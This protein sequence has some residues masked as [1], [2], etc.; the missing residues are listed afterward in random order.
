MSSPGQE[1][2]STGKHEA[3][4]GNSPA[5]KRV[6]LAPET[7]SGLDGGDSGDEKSKIVSEADVGITAYVN[8][9]L[10]PISGGIIKQRCVGVVKWQP[11]P[12][13]SLPAQVFGLSRPRGV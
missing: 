6:H 4:T 5:L 8:E 3:P 1:S 2:A 10:V 9:T 7:H 12:S 13:H 11:G